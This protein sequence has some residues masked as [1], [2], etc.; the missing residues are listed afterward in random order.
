MGS[1]N[2]TRNEK[3]GKDLLLKI[4]EE[5]VAVVDQTP[6]DEVTITAHGLAVNDL[7]RFGI[8]G[9]PAGA[10]A[11]T[12]YFVKTVTDA[13][14]VVLSASPGGTAIT[15]SGAFSGDVEVFKTIGGLRSK[16]FSFASEGI[17]VSNHGS[18]QWRNLLDGAGLKSVS[19]SGEGVYTSATNYRAAEA[20]AFANTLVCLAFIEVITGRIYSGCFKITAIEAS[21]EYDGESTYSISAES[22][23]EVTITQAA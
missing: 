2:T 18:N 6:N 11:G 20:A 23:G 9:T 7:V 15:F 13:N 17:D 19:V 22:A 8:D 1:C 14:N 3:G 10:T 5:I 21:G 4:C 16:S 12:L